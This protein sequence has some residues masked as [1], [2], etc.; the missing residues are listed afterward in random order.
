MLCSNCFTDEGLR[1]DAFRLGV[2]QPSVC[3]RCGTKEGQ[4][5]DREAIGVLA[6]RFFV[7]GTLRR[8]D[9]GAAPAIQFNEHQRGM[10]NIELPTWLKDDVELIE[11]AIGIGF[12]RYGPR[13]WMLGEVKPLKDL[14]QETGR[15]VVVSRI[16]REYPTRLLLANESL[17]RL[18]LNPKNPSDKQEFD[19]PPKDFLG[20][21]RLDSR[22]LP[23][24][25]CSRDIEGCVH[26]CRATMEDDLFVATLQPTR[27]L[28]LLD[29]TDLL[30]E[31]VTE[32]ESLDMAVHML[33]FA[34]AHSYEISRAIASAA[35]G[36]GFDGL[37]YPS[38]FSQARNGEMPFATAYGL[39]VRQFPSFRTHALSQITSNLCIFGRPIQ[40]GL[41]TVKCINR[42]VISKVMYD[43]QFGPV[44]Y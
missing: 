13:L 17:Y 12:F 7:R 32:F 23:V 28:R 11:A 10:G 9:Y 1:L 14:Q 40:E 21:G 43:I 15:S 38:Y 39:S 5:L 41:I 30:Q 36:A 8:F 34:R 4:K 25:Y 27:D 33:F 42:V 18:R 24:L 3:P 20:S 35:K 19:S 6:H 31:G 16:V 29:L 2:S 26:E 44:T 37:I 22:Q